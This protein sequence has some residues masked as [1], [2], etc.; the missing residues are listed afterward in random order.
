MDVSEMD[1]TWVPS[2]YICWFS[3]QHV[4]NSDVWD[5][6]ISNALGLGSYVL[7][8]T[9]NGSVHSMVWILD[10]QYHLKTKCF[11]SDFRHCLKSELLDNRTIIDVPKSKHSTVLCRQWCWGWMF[12][13]Y[14]DEGGVTLE[15]FKY[16][17]V[18]LL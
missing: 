17:T 12:M 16:V 15:D 3:F 13:G 10:A 4:L 14:A 5:L 18:C 7:N 11:R 9:K 6:K 8:R 1:Q 2:R